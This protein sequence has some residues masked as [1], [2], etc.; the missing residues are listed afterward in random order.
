MARVCPP[1]AFAQTSAHGFAHALPFRSKVR[2]PP[3]NEIASVIYKAGSRDDAA[4]PCGET[5]IPQ[6]NQPAEKNKTMGDKS[7][8]ANQKKS[9]QKQALQSSA[10]KQKQQALAAKSAAAHKKK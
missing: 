3:Q 9:S 1:C 7:P 10:D 6:V 2:V 4:P 8:K 5:N